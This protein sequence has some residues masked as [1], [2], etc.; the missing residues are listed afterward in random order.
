MP[1]LVTSVRTSLSAEDVILRAVQFFATESWRPTTQSARSAT[2]EGKP[3]IPC[4]LLILTVFA[5]ALLIVPGIIL[6]I[7]VIRK[8]YR[9]QNIVVTANPLPHGSEVILQYPPAA[10]K[11]VVGF[12]KA[13]PPMEG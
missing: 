6:W 10:K 5:F 1:Y 13:L 2:F 11:L 12:V 9:F 8:V 3:R 7:L 4:L